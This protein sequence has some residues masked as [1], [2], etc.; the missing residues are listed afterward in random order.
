MLDVYLNG[1]DKYS[2]EQ[3]SDE[4]ARAGL[5]GAL[6]TAVLNKDMTRSDDIAT[7]FNRA[8][9]YCK[10]YRNINQEVFLEMLLLLSKAGREKFCGAL[11]HL[12][13]E[14]LDATEMEEVIDAVERL[15]ESGV[16]QDM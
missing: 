6:A 10:A 16:L 2:K 3:A 8:Q 13:A 4:I 12:A 11:T 5:L 14:E 15:V 1:L 9:S 7:I